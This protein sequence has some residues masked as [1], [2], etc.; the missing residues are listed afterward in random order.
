MTITTAQYPARLDPR[1]GR[2]FAFDSRSL[3]YTVEA[4]PTYIN[5]RWPRHVDIYDQGQT[6]S[7]TGNAIAGA[8]ATGP[9][10]DALT[11]N[12]QAL[13]DGEAEALTLYE[14]ATQIDPFPG[15][16]P[17]DDTGS[18]GTSACKAAKAAGFIS[19]YRHALKLSTA[20][21]AVEKGPVITGTNWY[22][23][24]FYPDSNGVISISPD[25]EIAGGHEYC[26][27]QVLVDSQLIGFQNSW[28]TD[29]GI[30][31]RAYMSWDTWARLISENGD[32][33]VP[34]PLAVTPPPPTGPPAVDPDV[35]VAYQALSRWA[36]RNGV[37]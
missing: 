29:W 25:S 4:S 36:A 6:G 1:L 9:L 27:D 20:L 7:C 12:L 13:L 3:G 18:D 37:Q 31:G 35:L 32:V 19:A 22:E 15:A 17:P 26:V 23:S 33:T 10:W 14:A 24:M 5:V 8:A 16:Y 2:Q 30:K 34:Q 28:G 11:P 21:A